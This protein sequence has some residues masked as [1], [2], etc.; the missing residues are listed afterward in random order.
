VSPIKNTELSKY[1]EVGVGF[2]I[3]LLLG[4]EVVVFLFIP[5]WVQPE[6]LAAG[7]IWGAIVSVAFVI[8]L[9]TGLVSAAIV[10]FLDARNRK[11]VIV[12]EFIVVLALALVIL[13]LLNRA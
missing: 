8:T 3:G 6:G 12:V 7:A 1:L 4:F 2:L 10:F 5:D 11:R 13:V 9:P